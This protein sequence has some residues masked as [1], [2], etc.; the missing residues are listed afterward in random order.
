MNGTTGA[1]I[2]LA[3]MMMVL[4]LLKPLTDDGLLTAGNFLMEPM[5]MKQASK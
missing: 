1:V 4:I 5:Q 2:P 3:Q